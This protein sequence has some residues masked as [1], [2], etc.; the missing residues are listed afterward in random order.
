MKLITQKILNTS[1]RSKLSDQAS[2]WLDTALGKISPGPSSDDTRLELYLRMS[3]IARRK[4]GVTS[5]TPQSES[6]WLSDEAGRILL[7]MEFL[8]CYSKEQKV[9]LLKSIYNLIDENEKQVISKGMSLLDIEGVAADLAITIGRTNNINLFSSLA[10][11]N[12]YPAKYY[13]TRA[14]NQLVLKTLFMDLDLGQLRGLNKRLSPELTILCMD[15]VKERLAAD[16]LPPESICLAINPVD[17]SGEDQH[18]Y[19]NI[20]NKTHQNACL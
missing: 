11:N 15:L 19:K 20:I 5:L 8:K 14:F 7:L 4:L 17:L 16:R 9:E 12:D 2:G 3:A 6:G 18:F 13:D 1:L 10:L